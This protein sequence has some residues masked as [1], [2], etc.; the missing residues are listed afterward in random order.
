MGD[1]D[2]KTEAPRALELLESPANLEQA[3][4]FL[5]D[6]EVRLQS[7]ERKTEF[8]KTKGLQESQIAELLG[9]DDADAASTVPLPA[10]SQ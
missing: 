2:E 9:A 8:L 4:K 3:R 5:Q 7:R 1:S 10:F 6:D